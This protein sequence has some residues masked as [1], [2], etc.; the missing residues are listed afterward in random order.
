MPILIIAAAAV[1]FPLLILVVMYNNLV[2]TRNHCDE[3]WSNIDTELKRRYDLIPNLVSTVRGYAAHEKDLLEELARL[4]ESC[5]RDT[6]TPQHQAGNENQLVRTLNRL[7]ARVEAY[8]DL[9]ASRNFLELQEE[10]VNTEDRIQ[11]AR[12]YYNGNVREMNN[13][14]QTIPSSIVAS[15]GGFTAREFFEVERVSVREPVRVDMG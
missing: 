4:R 9:K 12:R 8:P 15:M 2:R 11:A 5:V 6:G 14:V 3:A 7:L 10:L 13:L 1:L